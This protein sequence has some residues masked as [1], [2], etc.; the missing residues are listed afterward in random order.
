MLLYKWGLLRAKDD[1]VVPF[2]Q[3]AASINRYPNLTTALSDTGGHM[4]L[5]NETAIAEAIQAFTT[6]AKS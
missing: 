2:T 6:P 1:K 5:G 4:L 3:V